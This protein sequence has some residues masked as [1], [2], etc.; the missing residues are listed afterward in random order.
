[1][2]TRSTDAAAAAPIPMAS[3]SYLSRA[4]VSWM[5]PIFMIGYRRQLQEEDVSEMIPEHKT[6]SLSSRLQQCWDAEL[7]GAA[8]KT[9]KPS[10][11]RALVRFAPGYFWFGQVCLFISGI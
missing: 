5:T 9:R 4:F 7:K 8:S 1:M 6:R 2:G 11:L 3:A 10:L